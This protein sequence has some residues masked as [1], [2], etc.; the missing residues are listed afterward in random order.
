MNSYYELKGEVAFPGFPKNEI[1]RGQIGDFK[2]ASLYLD[3]WKS[4]F[5]LRLQRNKLGKYNEDEMEKLRIE[6]E[7]EDKEEADKLATMKVGDR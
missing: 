4:W 1:N 2:S 7:L 5:F 3:S 6:K